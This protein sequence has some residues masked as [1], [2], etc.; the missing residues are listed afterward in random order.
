[1][2]LITAVLG[3]IPTAQAQSNTPDYWQFPVRA[4]LVQ[5]VDLNQ[6]SFLEF[7]IVD[8]SNIVTLLRSDGSAAWIFAPSQP[9]LTLNAID[10]DGRAGK[11]VVLATQHHLILLSQDGVEQWRVPIETVQLPLNLIASEGLEVKEQWQDRYQPQPLQITAV[12]F[13]HDGLQEILLLLAD[14]QIQLFNETGERVWRYHAQ[15]LPAINTAPQVSV[16]DIDGDGQ[17]EIALARG[18]GQRR[19]SQLILLDNSEEVWVRPIEGRLTTLSLVAFQPDTPPYIAVGTTQGDI[20]L[21]SANRDRL[22]LRTLNRPITTMTAVTLPQG[23]ALAVGTD[24][25]MVVTFNQQGQRY[26]TSR[27]DGQANRAV[28]L[29]TAVPLLPEDPIP[30]Q[31]I[32][33]ALLQN[34][35]PEPADVVLLDGTNGQPIRVFPALDELGASRLLDL[36]QDRRAEL[37]VT[38]N[39]TL[40]LYGLGIGASQAA[41]DWEYNLQAPATAW[42]QADFNLDGVEE[43]ILA[44]ADGRLHYLLNDGTH[45][46]VTPTNTPITKLALLPTDV[47]RPPDL[48]AVQSTETSSQITRWSAEG[49]IVWRITLDEVVSALLVG[50]LVAGEQVEF[51]IGTD[52]GR[53][54]AYR[55]NAE[56]IWQS[57]PLTEE[58]PIVQ[59]LAILR[60][61]NVHDTVLL[62]GTE[63]AVYRLYQIPGQTLLA[64]RIAQYDAPI[65]AL[66]PLNQ[67][68]T[69]LTTEFMVVTKD[70]QIFGH[71]WRGIL[72]PQW[73]LRLDTPIRQ[74]LLAPIQIEEAFD[75]I[76]EN[77]LP[78]N[79]NQTILLIDEQDRLIRFDIEGNIP[80][81]R[82]SASG[83]G[84][85]N[86][87][88]WDDMDGDN[89]PDLL[90]GTEEG[91]MHLYS[92]DLH[93]RISQLAILD[94]ITNLTTLRQTA[95]NPADVVALLANGRLQHFRTQ[96]NHPPLLMNPNVEVG[97]NQYNINVMVQDV[98]ESEVRVQ[99]ELFDPLTNEW[100]P[101]PDI[102]A[103]SQDGMLFWTAV[104]LPQTD[105]TEVRYRFAY[106]DGAYTGYVTPKPG[107]APIITP[108]LTGQTAVGWITLGSAGLLAFGLMIRQWQ[109]LPSRTRRFYRRVRQRPAQ[110]LS[111]LAQ[112]YTLLQGSADFLLYLA[113]TAREHE[114]H[115]VARLADGLFFLHNQPIAGLLLINE[116]LTERATTV[117]D[118]DYLHEWQTIYNT[119]YA[120]LS[121]PS[122]LE[123]SLRHPQFIG[124]QETIE[125]A[126]MFLPVLESLHPILTNLRD[127]ERVE[128]VEDRTVYLNEAL[129]L[130]KEL[131]NQL[132]EFPEQLEKRLV[133]A[134]THRWLGLIT[135]ELD[136]ISG[137][138]ELAISLKTQRIIA[139]D[140]AELLWEIKNIG[141]ATAE[142]LIVTLP[143]DP[144]YEWLSTPQTI[145]VIAPDRSRQVQFTIRPKAKD[146]F[147]AEIQCTYD[148]RTQRD[149]IVQF[150]DM[151]HLL[152][153]T[154]A[155]QKVL[156]LYTPGTPLRQ[157]NPLFVGRASLFQF[158]AE[159][160][161]QMT[162][163]NILILIGQRRTGKTSALLRLGQHLP[164]HLLPVYIDCQSLGVTA[165]MPALLHEIAWLISDTL[166]LYDHELEVPPLSKWKEDPTNYFQREFIPLAHALLPANN[167]LI[168][169]FDEFEAF[170][171]LVADGFLPRTVFPYLRHLMQHSERLG[172]IFV[173]TRKLEEMSTDYWS[174]LFN[175]ALYEKIGYL[176]ETSAK[177]LIQEPVA[178]HLVYDD[179]ALDKILRVTAGHPYFLQ[180]VCYTLVKQANQ[181]ELGYVTLSDVNSALDEMLSLGEMHFAFLW[182]RSSWVEKALLTAVAHLLNIEH[183]F[184]PTEII[185]TLIP[186]GFQLD[187]KE[188]THALN[189]LVERDIMAEVT[190]K[191]VTLYV[192]KVGLVGLWVAKNK[193]LSKLHG[194]QT[195]QP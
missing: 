2:L 123:L 124:L 56:L 183:P 49:H 158:I 160:M 121:A 36:N 80:K 99:L 115:H 136:H 181:K 175:I 150:A 119:S 144:A 117:D 6:D 53:V 57:E 66:Y 47:T 4:N 7:L 78:V 85:I 63:T 133:E 62:A 75:I 90:V 31:P 191:A 98:E 79:S 88:H 59:T 44:G 23:Q 15:S 28:Q 54:L 92:R 73:P 14:G 169:V 12:D 143:D 170:E 82:W 108:A 102:Q 122:I 29:L 9:V 5:T 10:V 103:V 116:L 24:V 135:A 74:S 118:W 104:D 69:E 33:S 131:T 61:N 174:V 58:Q 149:K 140:E 167:K 163:R 77:F 190:E 39:N 114:D 110:T 129:R 46:W 138:A 40:A 43:M 172:F 13:N 137:R 87:V 17:D 34:P 125:K 45:H 186:Y 194:E 37:L 50:N 120:L 147:R 67:S 184:S 185:Q 132:D 155:F 60:N 177:R 165:G 193:S 38:R 18:F 30:A 81:L 93:T 161:G 52:K 142:N 101:D 156:N 187:P 16:G 113:S 84:T 91:S 64:P 139:T 109:A 51:I 35:S 32:L 126:S 188:V 176:N 192:L 151:V 112:R 134:I 96:E 141:R 105:L 19:F 55:A 94:T 22:W 71:N 11:E 189:Q 86:T 153:P 168:L 41:R 65:Q 162:Q 25:G 106:D 89:L 152:T 173:G 72:L 157:N 1:M 26:W 145:P 20:Q 111:L 179:L 127:S 70:G 171:N 128:L 83:F 3:A 182:E 159:S 76:D 164:D 146:R 166:A 8:Q 48:L 68:G 154:R 178:P 107:P 97:P 130:L 195:T 21:F 148:D 100:Q 27:L 180:L 95:G 42:V